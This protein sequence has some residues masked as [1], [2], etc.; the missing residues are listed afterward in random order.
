MSS[1]WHQRGPPS[2]KGIRSELV[3]NMSFDGV[4]LGDTHS[5]DSACEGLAVHV[6]GQVHCQLCLTSES[7]VARQG[8]TISTQSVILHV[9]QQMPAWTY[10]S[11]FNI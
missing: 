6:S 3:A 5:T 2:T 8:G 9:D 10:K 11:S 4:R 1:F 7:K